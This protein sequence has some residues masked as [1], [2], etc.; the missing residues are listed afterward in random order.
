VKQIPTRQKHSILD[1]YNPESKD[2]E[3]DAQNL[4]DMV[5]ENPGHKKRK[6]KQEITE[7]RK[8]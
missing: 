3:D 8:E 6:S 4:I 7:R 1:I 2:E 5:F